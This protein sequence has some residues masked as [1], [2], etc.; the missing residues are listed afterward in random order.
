MK[1]I[2]SSMLIGLILLGGVIVVSER[3]KLS[4]G[5]LHIVFCDVGQGDAIYIKTPKGSDILVDGGPD[6]KV[7][8]C[9]FHHMPF[10]D[11][12]IEMMVLSHPQADHLTG[13][14]SV[15]SRYSLSYFVTSP[16][17]NVS[18]GY[19]KLVDLIKNNGVRVKNVY[20]GEVIDFGDGV[21][22]RVVWP[23]KEWTKRQVDLASGI[24]GGIGEIGDAGGILGASTIDK[25]LNDFS[26]MILVQMGEFDTLLSG[27]GDSRIESMVLADNLFP[28]IEVLK[29][30]HHGSKTAMT[31]KFIQTIHPS[32]SVI[33]V[34]KDNKYGHPVDS[35]IKQIQNM[36][37]QILRTDQK[38]EIVITSDGKEWGVR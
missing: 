27:D 36:G 14:I 20:T 31:E 24:N 8:G 17:G 30:P 21:S 22:F 1:K 7:L 34:G 37:S 28:S 33:S 11:R 2:V 16:A 23:E 18:L 6:E 25:E 5:K 4:D 13:L 10:W 38:G 26:T 3:Q 35:T 19:K 32:L 29:V 12:N 9:L 15:A